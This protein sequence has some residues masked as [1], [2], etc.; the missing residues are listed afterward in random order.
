MIVS[1]HARPLPDPP[2]RHREGVRRTLPSK[3][4]VGSLQRTASVVFFALMLA[5]T[6]L[7]APARAAL[8][9]PEEVVKITGEAFDFPTAPNQTPTL[10]VNAAI[11]PGWHINSNQPSSPDYIATRLAVDPPPSLRA[12]E[13]KYPPAETI[14]PEFS[15]GEKLSVFSGAVTFSVPLEENSQPQP[16]ESLPFTL[17]LDYQACNDRQCLR[18]VTITRQTSLHW[19]TAGQPAAQ[20]QPLNA[21]RAAPAAG[22][23]FSRYG[24]ALG[25]VLV[26]LG[27]LALNLTPC[28]YPLIGVTIAYFGNQGGG[29]TRRILI[30]ALLYVAGIA[31]MFSGIGTAAALSGGLFGAILENPYVLSAI[32][33]LMLVLA[34]SSFGWFTLQAPHWMLQRAGTARPGYLGALAMGLGMGVVAAPCIGPF[35]LGLLLVVERSGNALLG[36]AVFFVLALGMGI[37]YIVLAMAVGSIRSLPRSGEWLAWI[38]HLFGF[39]LIGLALYFVDPLLPGR[40]GTRLL[41]YY[42]A[43]AGIYLGFISPH[44]RQPRPFAL[45]KL[46]VG[47]ASLAALIYFVSSRGQVPTLAFTPFNQQRLTA[48]A[49]AHRP[50]LIDFGADWC[51]PCREMEHTT[52]TDPAVIAEARRFVT[53]HADL[54]RLDHHNNELVSQFR[55]QGVPTLLLLDGAGKLHQRLVGYIGPGEMLESLKAVN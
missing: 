15:M 21:D 27:G 20:A 7:P 16:G 34:A 4:I 25:F 13:I 53:L 12:R 55:I 28:V 50:V 46:A 49:A 38:E 9:K 3:I 41:P 48:A 33:A 17:T 22:D 51:I 47:A 26:L 43:A 37:P 14:A 39:V 2:L 31:L 36:F 30:L 5:L 52:F 40:L 42:G 8:P 54:T 11:L 23:L 10:R 45:F 32:A 29:G 44:G 6:A 24:F 18:P 35:V 1:R 19:P